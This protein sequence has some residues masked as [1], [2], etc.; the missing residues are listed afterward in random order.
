VATSIFF[1]LCAAAFL[2]IYA[3]ALWWPRAT[4]TGAT[5]SMLVGTLVYSFMCIFVY[6]KES[7]IFGLAKVLFGKNS[8]AGTGPLSYIDPL[9]IALPA[10]IIVFIIASLVT[11]PSKSVA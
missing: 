5:W 11:K 10:S 4:K 8:L 9:I 6:T 7:A 3:G 1:G 2:P